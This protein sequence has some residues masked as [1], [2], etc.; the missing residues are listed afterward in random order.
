MISMAMK[1]VY[2][3][4]GMTIQ[5]QRV[6]GRQVLISVSDNCAGLP[7]QQAYKM[8]DGFLPPGLKAPAW[9]F[10]SAALSLHGIVGP[11]GVPLTLR[12]AQP[13]ISR[14]P[15]TQRYRHDEYK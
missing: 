3:T 2:G 8:F 12:A 11:C 6:E 15:L 1:D 10:G 4:R 13:F 9:D 7:P 14:Y 5:P